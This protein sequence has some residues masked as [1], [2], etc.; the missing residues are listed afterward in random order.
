MKTGDAKPTGLL[1]SLDRKDGRATEWRPWGNCEKM[2]LKPETTASAYDLFAFRK[3]V[4]SSLAALAVFAVLSSNAQAADSVRTKCDQ[5]VLKRSLDQDKKGTTTVIVQMKGDM[6]DARKAS[7]SEIGGTVVRSFDI[8]DGA[9]VTLPNHNLRQLSQFSWVKR[10]STNFTVR[11]YDDFTTKHTFADTQWNGL[12]GG[13]GYEGDNINIAVVDSGIQPAL[14]FTG[15]YYSSRLLLNVN[16]SL[17]LSDVATE[18]GMTDPCGHGTHVAGIAAG[19]GNSASG[20]NAKRQYRGSA[21]NAN[22]IGVRVLERNGT[23]T[24]DTVLAGLQWVYNN[25]TLWNIRVV[26]LS[27]GHPVG[28]SYKT[29]PMCVMMK[30]LWESGVVVVCAAGNMGRLNDEQ[31]ECNDNEGWG[32]AYGSIQ[33]P[34]NSPHVITVGAMKQAPTDK[35]TRVKDKVATYSS[36][37]PS[38]FDYVLK[39]DVVAPGNLVVSIGPSAGYL[40]QSHSSN[41]VPVADYLDNPNIRPLNSNSYYVLSGTSMAAPAVAGAVAMILEKSPWLT[42]DTVKARLMITADKWAYPGSYKKSMVVPNGDTD[43]FT[44]GAGFLNVATAINSTFVP[45]G[46]ALSPCMTL[47]EK[48]NL[49]FNFDNTVWTNRAVWGSAGLDPK[50]IWGTRAVWG[51]WEVGGLR[52]VWGTTVGMVEGTRAVWG[53]TT[54]VEETRAVWGSANPTCDLTSIALQGEN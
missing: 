21:T 26:N 47:D 35:L 19:S 6:T 16:F 48:G 46:P 40:F 51:N 5:F 15:A 30:Q 53:N 23:G 52:A 45:A 32:T 14:D 12:P 8:I 50:M 9:T 10:I 28:E 49:V 3:P 34:G 39:P 31:N 33:V 36:R 22:L 11:K 4:I 27:L 42:P 41:I 20:T 7:I 37:G 44:F 43:P 2:G 29:D 25:R 13:A 17:G 24:V 38:I 1:R 54:F 18:M